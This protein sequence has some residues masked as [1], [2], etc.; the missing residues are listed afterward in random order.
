MLNVEYQNQCSRSLYPLRSVAQDSSVAYTLTDLVGYIADYTD[1]EDSL[2]VSALRVIGGKV[3]PVLGYTINGAATALDTSISPWVVVQSATDVGDF[4]TFRARN[5][6]DGQ[7]ATSALTYTVWVPHIP[8]DGTYQV[9]SL[10]IDRAITTATPQTSINSVAAGQTLVLAAGYNLTAA[11]GTDANG[12][13]AITLSVAAGDGAGVVPA[14]VS[15]GTIP[16]L[17]SVGGATADANGNV[18]ISTA[19]CLNARLGA[20]G[21]SLQ[22]DDVCTPCMDC[23]ALASAYSVLNGTQPNTANALYPYAR[24][25]RARIHQADKAFALHNKIEAH[26]FVRTAHATYDG[27]NRLLYVTIGVSVGNQ[28]ANSYLS[29]AFLSFLNLNSDGALGVTPVAPF[30]L[31]MNNYLQLAGGSNPQTVGTTQVSAQPTTGPSGGQQTMTADIALPLTPE[32]LPAYEPLTFTAV[33]SLTGVI[34][35]RFYAFGFDAGY[36]PLNGSRTHLD[37]PTATALVLNGG[38]RATWPTYNTIQFRG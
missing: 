2:G 24:A 34:P 38:T 4:R 15:E 37:R 22:L 11:A 5:A 19:A 8:A 17:V 29:S 23:Q 18:D 3:Y 25:L 7:P 12:G 26:G 9:G 1:G 6:H 32:F 33:F 28:P 35:G 31:N 10:L 27:T 21:L 13:Q 30:T 20:D 16:W 14:P 36:T